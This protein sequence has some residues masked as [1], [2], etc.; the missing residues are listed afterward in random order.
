MSRRLEKVNS[1]I[2]REIMQIIQKE[3]DDPCMELVSITKVKT[4]SDLK[5]AHIYFSV[6]KEEDTEK[7][8]KILNRMKNYFRRLL[9]KR[10]RIKILPSLKFFPDDSIRYSVEIYKKIEEV[11]GDKEDN[12]D[13][14]RE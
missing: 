1:Q 2:K 13:Y 12:S 9:G 3:V 5:E 8:L 6:L 14:K 10:M 7:V 4:T 11:M